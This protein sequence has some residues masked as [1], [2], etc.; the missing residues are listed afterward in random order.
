MAKNILIPYRGDL[1]TARHGFNAKKKQNLRKFKRDL[2]KLWNLQ[3]TAWLWTQSDKYVNP[4]LQKLLGFEKDFMKGSQGLVKIGVKLSASAD[5]DKILGLSEN[6]KDFLREKCLAIF[7][8][9]GKTIKTSYNADKGYDFQTFLADGTETEFIGQ[10]DEELA[11]ILY[12]RMVMYMVDNDSTDTKDKWSD[13][14][15]NEVDFFNGDAR[16]KLKSYKYTFTYDDIIRMIND[17]LFRKRTYSTLGG[18]GF[19]KNETEAQGIDMAL[20]NELLDGGTSDN[21]NED[22][23]EWNGVSY[24]LKIDNIK[25]LDE[26]EFLIFIQTHLTIDK[27]KPKK[28]WYQKGVFG[29][30]FA[31]IIVVIAVISQQYWLIGVGLGTTLVVAGMII[32]ITGALLGNEV[33]M[34]AGQIVSLVGGGISVAEAIMAEQVAME[35][36]TQQM[37]SAGVEQSAMQQA[38]KIM[39]DDLLLNTALGVG[40]FAMSTY[41]TITNLKG[42]T[43]VE[44]LGEKVTPAE[45]INE[46]YVADDIGWDYVQR[47]MPDFI[48]ANSLRL[49]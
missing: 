14:Y 26:E 43:L 5:V 1:V 48:I 21:V 33:M 11:L 12:D 37:V 30:V 2:L 9:Y 49:M 27:K 34:T 25:N 7:S 19:F 39:A 4:K 36:F 41:T 10:E 17:R 28:K 16:S 20:F 3:G 38:I 15:G 32:S 44:D 46:I 29:I 18:T 40:K 8:K 47:F 23:W 22:Y 24:D 31:V 45:K 42:E 35:A 6:N 13:N